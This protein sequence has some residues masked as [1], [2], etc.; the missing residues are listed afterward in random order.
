MQA[1]N[2]KITFVCLA[3]SIETELN[4][5]SL[6]VG[7]ANKSYEKPKSFNCLIR[8]PAIESTPGKT[9]FVLQKPRLK[10]E[11]YFNVDKLVNLM[12]SNLLTSA[13][14]YQQD[15]M[16]SSPSSSFNISNVQMLSDADTF[17]RDASNLPKVSNML[18]AAD[19]LS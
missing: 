3:K 17:A 18:S 11:N 1:I 19:L 6:S 8:A 14:D 2:F 16:P 13:K 9:S 10:I 4:G 12:G 15:T 5:I 7:N